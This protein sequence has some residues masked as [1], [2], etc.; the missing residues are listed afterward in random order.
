MKEN[1]KLRK[2]N[3][4]KATLLMSGGIDS[5]ACAH[6]LL[7]Q[8][9]IVNGLFLD[10]GQAAIAHEYKAIK[11]I[12]GHF[13]I[14]IQILRTMIGQKYKQGE[15]VGRNALLIFS[16]LMLLKPKSGIITLGVHSGTPYYDC[17]ENFIRKANA[18]VSEY[19]DGRV[20][21]MTPFLTWHKQDIIFYCQQN[22]IPLKL[23]YSC[24]KGTMPPCG[25]C[26]S[27]IDRGEL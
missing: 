4:V 24:E 8:G 1:T 11:K 14:P 16:A 20:E 9:F 18:I 21:L 6:F 2:S 25:K 3:R 17:S 7:K 27:C 22:K 15:I 19:T 12:S 10:Y 23:T 5:T 26:L 13:D